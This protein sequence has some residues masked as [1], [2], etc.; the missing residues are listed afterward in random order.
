MRFSLAAAAVFVSSSS[1]GAV[2]FSQPNVTADGFFSDSASYPPGVTFMQQAV[3]DNFSLGTASTI[4]QV[5]FWGSSENV[6]TPGLGNFTQFH[7]QIY[8]ASFSS[9]FSAFVP[10]AALTPVATGNVNSAGGQEHRFT[11][12]TA[13]TLGAGSYWLH[14]GAIYS[15]PVNDAFIWSSANGNGISA[16]KDL[17]GMGP[18]TPWPNGGLD[19]AFE[20]RGDVVPEPASLAALGLGALALLRRRRR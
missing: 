14:V 9:L 7:V 19:Q 8:N 15:N 13:I 4:H 12:N 5:V 2:L 1:F 3:A 10:V 17:S 18:W 20:L 11:Y 6:F 16:F